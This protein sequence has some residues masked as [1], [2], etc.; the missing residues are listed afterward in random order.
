MVEFEA[1]VYIMAGIALLTALVLPRVFD[2]QPLSMPMI[3]VGTGFILFSLPM[4]A[5]LPNPIEHSLVVEHL[6]ELVV[7]ISLMGAGLKID[8]PFSLRGW[9]ITWR[10]LAIAM[11]LTVIMTVFLGWWGLGMAPATAILLGAVVAPTDPVLA[12]EVE[13]SE[14]LEDIDQDTDPRYQTGDIRFGL[15]SEAGLNDGLAFPVTN[16][17]VAAA[18]AGTY[19]VGVVGEWMLVDVLYKIVVGVLVGYLVGRILAVIIFRSI[20]ASGLSRIITGAEALAATFL[21]YGMTELANGY[22]FI[23]VF[24]GSLVLR[25]YEWEHEYYRTLHRFASIIEHLLMGAVLVLFGGAIASGLLDPLNLKSILVG[26]AL[27]FLVRPVAGIL[28]LVGHSTTTWIERN[29]IGG[30][31]I[32]GIGSFYYL[33]YALNEASFQEYELLLA[34][35]E[36]WAIVGF[37]VLISI[38]FHGLVV[39]P[40]M[41]RVDRI[42]EKRSL[43]EVE[44]SLKEEI[45]EEVTEDDT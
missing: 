7:I 30:F 23:A 33:S 45:A 22:G 10:L 14:P 39:G 37:F 18:A 31:G 27:I 25:Y 21:A 3:Y 32:R 44:D 5:V 41:Q 20:A 15:T 9:G 43:E 8:R 12:S 13:A 38:F 29:I 42:R 26:L 6:T 2:Y 40:I 28:S 16:L 34:R 36:I 24:V 35:E 1:V 19:G 17:A 4:E 11:P